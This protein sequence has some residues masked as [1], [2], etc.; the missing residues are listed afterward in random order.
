[1]LVVMVVLMGGGCYGLYWCGWVFVC[2]VGWLFGGVVEEENQ[3]GFI[4]P[5]LVAAACAAAAATK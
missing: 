3:R 5:R 2:A 4:T 1:M